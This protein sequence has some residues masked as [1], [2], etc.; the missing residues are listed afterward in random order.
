MRLPACDSFRIALIVYYL[1]KFGT[2]KPLAAVASCCLPV[3][4]SLGVAVIGLYAVRKPLAQGWID[5]ELKKRGVTASYQLTQLDPNHQRLEHV[6]IGDP[7]HPDLTADSIETETSVGLFGASLTG[8]KAAGVQVHGVLDKDGSLH[9]GTLDKFR[10]G[11][12]GSF[13]LPDLALELTDGRL[14]LDTPYGAVNARL[15]GKG[16]LAQDFAGKLMVQTAAIN[17][18]G[19]AVSPRNPL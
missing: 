14:A 13:R 9:F 16:N 2:F 18:S 7:S 12:S 4:V 19:C 3:S 6:I 8:V 1:S 10:T 17:A 5:N 15:D 11:G